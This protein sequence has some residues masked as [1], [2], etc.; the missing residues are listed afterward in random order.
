MVRK[1][2]RRLGH[3]G[4]IIN[5][6]GGLIEGGPVPMLCDVARTIF[7]Y[8]HPAEATMTDSDVDKAIP[9]LW[10]G[11]IGHLKLQMVNLLA[12]LQFKKLSQWALTDNKINEVK[13][14][15]IDYWAAFGK[16]VLAKDEALFGQG[17]TF[18]K[19]LEDD[20]ENIAMPNEDEIQVQFNILIR[21]R[22]ASSTG[23]T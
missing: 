12:H 1:M 10:Y 17:K 22:M 21:N 3:Q 20:E 19:I 7:Q 18:V 23:N 16:A 9:V 8:L 4:C 15:G 2:H 11:Q 14:C 13:A 5:S 6:K